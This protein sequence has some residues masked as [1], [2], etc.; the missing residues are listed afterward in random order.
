MSKKAVSIIICFFLIFTAVISTSK[1]V[2]IKTSDG[3][4][5]NFN[6]THTVFAEV[7]TSQNC[8]PCDF[9]NE[10]IYNAY[11]SGDYNFEFVEMIV[12]N[13]DGNKLN[14]EAFNWGNNYNIFSYPTS[15]F[16]ADFQRITGNYPSQL[17]NALEESENRIVKD[18]A[19]TMT[20]TWLG[21][22]TIK[23]DIEIQNNEPTQYQGHIRASITEIASRYNTYNGNPYHFGFLDFAFNKDIT[24]NPGSKYTDS[25]TWNGNDHHD[26]QGN[27]FGDIVP[28][29]IQV[30]M[31]I[32]NNNNGYA[33]E[34][35][36]ARVSGQ[37]SPPNA[38]GDPYPSNGENKIDVNTDLYWNCSD[39]D[40]DPLTYDVYFGTNNPPPL[41]SS[42]QSQNSYDPGTITRENTYYWKIVAW[43]NNDASTSGPIWSFVTKDKS[44]AAPVVKILKPDNGLYLFN[45]KIIPGLIRFVKIIGSITIEADA[46]DIDSG[47]DRV[48]FYIN[49]K[50]KYTDTTLPFSYDFIRDHF[51][52]FHYYFIKVIAYDTDGKT[53]VDQILVKKIL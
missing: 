44:N 33:D 9:W 30:T 43:D 14:Q 21:S 47:I 39:P 6:S 15:I 28:E 10:N 51:T 20:L 36:A 32:T 41:V 4:N 2:T 22:A 29:N 40:G 12:F 5:R 42:H 13:Y 17:P 26:L 3:E 37:N 16:D 35:V 50:L 45:N 46:T 8:E 18:I 24:I 23:V 34:T 53:A 1:G 38:P 48:E 11:I 19:A 7:A 31:G 25:T 49:G 27:S 52:F